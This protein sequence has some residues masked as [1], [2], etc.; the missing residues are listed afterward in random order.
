MSKTTMAKKYYVVM[1]GVML[2][3]VLTHMQTIS[4]LQS[5]LVHFEFSLLMIADLK[6]LGHTLL[7][8]NI[9][10]ATL[11]TCITSDGFLFYSI[12]QTRTHCVVDPD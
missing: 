11:R 4:L 10:I 1:L 6:I 8:C 7:N 12:V 2:R 9:I 5:I 3:L